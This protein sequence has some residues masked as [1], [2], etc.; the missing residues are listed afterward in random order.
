VKPI[1]SDGEVFEIP[2]KISK[3]PSTSPPTSQPSFG[4]CMTS[5][6]MANMTTKQ[7]DNVFG[8]FPPP[9]GCG[10]HLCTDRDCIPHKA[11]PS[12]PPPSFGYCMTPEEMAN[13]FATFPAP[14]KKYQ[15]TCTDKSCHD[16]NCTPKE[17]EPLISRDDHPKSALEIDI[18]EGCPC[19]FNAIDLDETATLGKFLKY[20]HLSSASE[21][22]L[23]TPDSDWGL[24]VG[25]AAPFAGI[26][27]VAAYRNITGGYQTRQKL[28][29]KLQEVEI[30]IKN[31]PTPQRIAYRDCLQYSLFDANWNI[32]VPGALNGTSSAAVI[33]TL[34]I[35]SPI[36]IPAIGAYAA[37]QTGRG[38][39]DSFRTWNR[40]IGHAK[41]DQITRSKRYFYVSTTSAFGL[42]TVVHNCFCKIGF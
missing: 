2:P 16:P 33:S 10:N 25:I 35:S 28:L 32:A 31:D 5:E 12:T 24:T 6:Q 37:A 30:L 13:M 7:V 27:L 8:T 15:S 34:I 18:Q 40:Y 39:Y 17:T 36:A 29:E 26:G 38:V 20:E 23:I 19:C 11:K 42:M 22:D 1:T 21:F 9:P 3:K 14:R 41:I 4:Y